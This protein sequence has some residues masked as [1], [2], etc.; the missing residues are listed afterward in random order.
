[1][2]TVTAKIVQLCPSPNG[3]FAL[4][5]DGRVFERTPD[6][7]NFDPKNQEKRIWRPVELPEQD[8]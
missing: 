5:S 8:K 2:T 7:R 6:P 3:L 1:M 4:M